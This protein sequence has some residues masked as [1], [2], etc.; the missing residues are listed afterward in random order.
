MAA[1][2]LVALNA[3][4]LGLLR[5]ALRRIVVAYAEASDWLVLD[6]PPST[7]KKVW[8]PGVPG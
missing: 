5:P 3:V 7:K 1:V 4:V 8:K 6:P 2:A